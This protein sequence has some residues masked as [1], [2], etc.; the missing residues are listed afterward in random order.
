MSG[1]ALCVEDDPRVAAAV[2]EV[3]AA[4]GFTVRACATVAAALR[5]L[6]ARP[7]V[8]VVDLGL[9]DGSGVE[10]IHALRARWPDAPVVV[11]TV[12]DR[13]AQVL[14]ALRA[15]ARGYVLKGELHAWLPAAL[16]DAFSGRMPLS[17]EAARAVRDHL[18]D[19]C[20]PA[21]REVLTPTEREVLEGLSRGLSYEQCARAADVSVNTVRTHV[22]AIYRKLEVSSKTEAVLEALRRGV[23]EAP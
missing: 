4:Q 9:P 20:A 2:S 5:A 23:I 1:E 19:A 7:R 8:A 3:L 22:R 11:L 17:P 12:D 18:R 13:P 6:R 10:V 21:E 15:G 16:A 14:D